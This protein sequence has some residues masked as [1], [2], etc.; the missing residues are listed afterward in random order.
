MP[1]F[2]PIKRREL[3]RHLRKLGFEGPYAGGRHEHRVKGT[4][5]LFIPNP[6]A[7]EISKSLLSK[8]LRQAEID[9]DEWAE[10]G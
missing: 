6:R 1:P 7:G 9:R 2:G 10:L 8:I 4:L 3:I 5:K